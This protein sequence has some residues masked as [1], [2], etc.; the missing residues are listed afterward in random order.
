ML[1]EGGY[2][3]NRLAIMQGDP[4]KF[5]VFQNALFSMW[6]SLADFSTT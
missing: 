4:D 2:F 1:V 6:I 3:L 5:L